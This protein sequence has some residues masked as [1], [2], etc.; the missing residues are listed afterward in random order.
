[1]IQAIRKSRTFKGLCLYVVMSILAQIVMPTVSLALTGGPSQPE[2]SSFTPSG[3]SDMVDLS[4][5]DFSYNIPLLDVGGYPVNIAYN[6]GAGMDDEA[7]A[8]GL[9]WNLSVGQIN[10]NVRGLPDDFK[11]DEMM[12]ENDMKP[13]FTVGADFKFNPCALGKCKDKDDDDP[14][15]GQEIFIPS[16]LTWGLSVIYNNY[17]GLEIKPTLGYEMSRS[18]GF[19]F[20][21]SEDG[22]TISP[23]ISFEKV[24]RNEGKKNNEAFLGAG[25]GTA[26]NSRQGLQSLTL[27]AKGRTKNF[28]HKGFKTQAM[29]RGSIGSTIDFVDNLY[30]PNKR[31]AMETGRFTLNAA[32]GAEVFGLE[33]QGQVMAYGTLQR[34]KSEEKEKYMKAFG[35]ANTEAAYDENPEKKFDDI[36]DF[37]REKDAAVSKNTTNLPLTNYTYDIYSVQGQGVAGVYRAHRSQ[38]GYVYDPYVEDGSFSGSLGAEFGT[39]NSL[40]L[41]VD[42]EAGF[43]KSHSGLWNEEN[44]I[45]A[46]LNYGASLA[47]EYEPVYYKNVGSLAEDQNFMGDE[48]TQLFGYTGNYLAAR[49]PFVGKKFHRK[50][51]SKFWAKIGLDPGLDESI[52]YVNEEKPVNSQIRRSKRQ[53]RGQV[54]TNITVKQLK[55]GMGLGPCVVKNAA[56]TPEYTLPSYAKD[57]HTAEVQ[58]LRNDGARY[59]YGLPVYNKTKKECT[60]SLPHANGDLTTGEATYSLDGSKPDYHVEKSEEYFNRIT[61]PAYVHTHLLTSIL[62]TDYQD[63]GAAGPSKED[64]G[65]YTKFVYEQVNSE[66]TALYKWRVPYQNA[67]YNEGLRTDENDD[68]ANYTYGE[69]ESFYI[70]QIITKTHIAIFEYNDRKDGLG[71][72]GEAGGVGSAKSKKLLSVKLYTLPEYEAYEEEAVPIKTVHFRYNYNLCQ[73]VPN[74]TTGTDA[75][76]SSNAGGKLTLEKIYFTYRNS[77]MGKYDAYNFFYGLSID[78]NPDYHFKAYD[79]WGNYLP[80][81]GT[82]TNTGEL[83]AP[84]FPYTSQDSTEQNKRAAVWSIRKIVL[85]SGGEINVSYESDDYAY[86]QNKKALM[87]YKVAGAGE[88]AYG[89][90]NEGYPEDHNLVNPTAYTNCPLYDHGISNKPYRY[91][92]VKIPDQ[93][94]EELDAA[95]IKSRYLSNFEKNLM[96]F[97]FLMNMTQ[98]GGTEPLTNEHKYDYVS[99]Y[100]ELDDSK[101]PV[102]F[103]GSDGTDYISV[104]VKLVNKE[105]GVISPAED[106]NPISKAAWHFARKY[107][108]KY[109]YS[110]QPNGDTDDFSETMADIFSVDVI[111]NLVEVFNGP[112]ST[113]E[114]KFV[115]RDFISNKS[116]VRLNEPTGKKLGGGSRVRQITMSDIW[117]EMNP[118]QSNYQTM[119]YGQQYIYELDDDKKFSSG[120]ATYE[121]VGNSENPFVQPVYS[122]IKHVLAPDEENYLEMPFGESFFPSPQ[123]TYS[124]VEVRSLAAAHDLPNGKAVKRMHKTGRIVTEFYTSKDFPTIVDQTELQIEEDERQLLDNLLNI[125]IKKHLTASQGYMIHLNDMNGKQKSQRVY[126]EGEDA[127]ISGVDYKYTTKT[128]GNPLTTGSE[129]SVENNKGLLDNTVVLISPKGKV[130]YG[131]LGVESDVINDFRENATET[132][133]FGINSNLASFLVTIFPALIP[134]PLPDY[135]KVEDQFRSATTTKVINTFGILRETVVYDGSSKV[136]TKNLAWDESTGEVLL[137]ETTDEYNDKYYSF[138]YP[139]H[140]NYKAMGLAATNIGLKGK[141]TGDGPYGLFF[142]GSSV[143]LLKKYFMEGD[144]LS[145]LNNTGYFSKAWVVNLTNTSFKLIDEL[146]EEIEDLDET[147]FELTRSGYRN[148]SAASMMQVTLMRNPLEYEGGGLISNLDE[149]FLTADSWQDYRI[150]NSGAVMYSDNWPVSCECGVISPEGTYNPYLVNAKGVW[151]LLSNRTYLTGRYYQP[152]VTPRIDGFFTKFKPMY[153]VSGLGIWSVSTPGWTFISEASHYSPYGQEVESVD[154]L[155]RFSAAVYGY[156]NTFPMAVGANARYTELAFDGFEDYDFDLCDINSHFNFKSVLDDPNILRTKNIAHTGRYSLKVKSGQKATII[157]KLD[158]DNIKRQYTDIELQG[159]KTKN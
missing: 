72:A 147:D 131:V 12:Y 71:T 63:R 67:N 3:T 23:D 152:E 149:S 140:W 49:I 7:S 100:C 109:A 107:L 77:N 36:L 20:E 48:S 144:E 130:H 116:W 102:H 41:G 159:I 1:M 38:V 123:V 113:L 111:S 129:M 59:V 104:P 155:G 35:Y 95:K 89:N 68:L 158:C 75:Y 119:N 16:K 86:V 25:I 85:P 8:V 61:T 56:S 81:T 132:R 137:T 58:V 27:Y 128:A 37:N 80:N 154:A 19:N 29:L 112:N 146:G 143:G 125:K 90:S 30:T 138:N 18:I 115:G 46:N 78:E 74:H 151:R 14:N 126:A 66:S 22:L 69:K 141:L 114:N 9:G 39:G 127:F 26:F 10:R 57:H 94:E 82:G 121:P 93:G 117:E 24:I 47:V 153:Q 124:R 6:S 15:T 105:G 106:V 139:A 148:L 92:Y 110:N 45:I 101:D 96:Q 83:T 120:V 133:T 52:T 98:V 122:T 51:T 145:Y 21:S 17:A 136:S 5:G 142:N 13:N 97:R 76:E 11:G 43:V 31:L 88:F 33:G 60:F 32:L 2:F 4:S 84:E 118:D 50:A 156:N 79:T 64:L 103:V 134:V 53:L 55:E 65:T 70:K 40:H 99:G 91:L 108:S 42:L 157:K 62:S 34:L 135:T 44:E 54:I 87:M 73:G 150:I 28:T